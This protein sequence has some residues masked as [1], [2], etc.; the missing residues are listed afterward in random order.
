MKE[1]VETSQKGRAKLAAAAAAAKE[2]L[3]AGEKEAKRKMAEAKVA[4]ASMLVKQGSKKIMAKAEQAKVWKQEKTAKM[5][6]GVAVAN[7]RVHALAQAGK[8][9]AL[10]TGENVQKTTLEKANKARA[11]ATKATAAAAETA[12]KLSNKAKGQ[13]RR[14]AQSAAA[15][16]DFAKSELTVSIADREKQA[17]GKIAAVKAKTREQVESAAAKA[18]EWSTGDRVR[19][20]EQQYANACKAAI[21]SQGGEGHGEAVRERDELLDTLQTAVAKYKAAQA[22]TGA[23]EMEHLGAVAKLEARAAEE[24]A[25]AE[26]VT[27]AEARYE[28][29]LEEALVAAAQARENL[30]DELVAEASAAAQVAKEQAAEAAA[31][32]AEQA[33]AVYAAATTQQTE[34][35]QKAIMEQSEDNKVVIAFQALIAKK[36]IAITALQEALA[37]AKESHAATMAEQAASAAT[38]LADKVQELGEDHT[39]AL[40]AKAE[41]KEDA[42]QQQKDTYEAKIAAAADEAEADKMNA[43]E[44]QKIRDL[45]AQFDR[46]KALTAGF[47]TQLANQKETAEAKMNEAQKAFQL[48]AEKA[49]L[50]NIGIGAIGMFVAA[51]VANKLF[52][53]TE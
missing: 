9:F 26:K 19:S 27:E 32:D 38:I 23:E 53:P 17:R 50:E 8:E 29:A 41:E 34:A 5:S 52:N 35:H 16:A 33:R 10:E 22:T 45:T 7:E 48:E 12:R 39:A 6:A 31:A 11:T 4:A 30:A 46:V 43:L 15:L 20:L 13:W 2:K 14:F 51:F 37:E 36:D 24:A 47:Q 1:T 49:K 40:L 42:L 28:A 18:Q 44:E 25:A 21:L 3:D